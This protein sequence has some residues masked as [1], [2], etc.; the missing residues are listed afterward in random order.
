M[1]AYAKVYSDNGVFSKT[2]SAVCDWD[3][4]SRCLFLRGRHNMNKI[5]ELARKYDWSVSMGRRVRCPEHRG[6]RSS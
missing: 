6:K 4:C 5:I 3:G 2:Y 1:I